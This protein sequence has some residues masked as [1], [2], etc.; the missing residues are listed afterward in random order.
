[1]KKMMK[2]A[3]ELKE[4]NLADVKDGDVIGL[5]LKNGNFVSGTVVSSPG[6]YALT[7]KTTVFVEDIA[8]VE[9]AG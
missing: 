2:V 9:Y 4:M 1:M 7:I 8:K 6:T 5:T 3:L